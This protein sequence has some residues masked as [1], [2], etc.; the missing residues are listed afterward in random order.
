MKAFE[1]PTRLTTDKRI[2]LPEVLVDRI[3]HN[4]LLRVVVLVREPNIDPDE[5]EWRRVSEANFLASYAP[6][7]SIYDTLK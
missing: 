1:F 7:D 6:E 4:K 3:P 5:E 2:K